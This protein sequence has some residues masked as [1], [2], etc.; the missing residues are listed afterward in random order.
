MPEVQEANIRGPQGIQ[1]ERGERGE[2]GPEGPEGP[3]GPQGVTGPTG[4]QGPAGAR[5]AGATVR[6]GTVTTLAPGSDATVSNAGTDTDAVLNFGIPRGEPG[7]GGAPNR[8]MKTMTCAGSASM[9]NQNSSYA[10]YIT[11]SLTEAQIAD[12]LDLINKA[13]S[14][15]VQFSGSVSGSSSIIGLN[16]NTPALLG[17]ESYNGPRGRISMNMQ[18]HIVP[19]V[20]SDLP[21][22]SCTLN[23]YSNAN[24]D[25]LTNYTGQSVSVLDLQVALRDITLSGDN[26]FNVNLNFSGVIY[27]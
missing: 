10:S 19:L 14:V 8:S 2:T 6:V 25:G 17:I 4:P 27:D 9:L 3:E 5:G 12:L 18:T 13:A 21:F 1:G 15:V 26:T 20:G 16:A 23:A 11:I 7:S 22:V 24:G